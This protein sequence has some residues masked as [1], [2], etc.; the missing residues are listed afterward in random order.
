[1]E[2]NVILIY[3]V[4]L[5]IMIK[6]FLQVMNPNEQIY[7]VIEIVMMSKPLVEIHPLNVLIDKTCL[8]P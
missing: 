4:I 3:P 2:S 8:A 6:T 1:M 7:Y 5:P